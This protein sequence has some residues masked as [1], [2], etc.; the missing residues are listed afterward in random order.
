MTAGPGSL[1][2]PEECSVDPTPCRQAT[3]AFSPHKT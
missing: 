3:G 2:D 1:M